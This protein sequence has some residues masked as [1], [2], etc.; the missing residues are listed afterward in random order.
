MQL[1][2]MPSQPGQLGCG[3]A[4][5]RKVA[6]QVDKIR[7]VAHQPLAFICRAAVAPQNRG[8]QHLQPVIEQDGAMHLA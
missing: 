2:L 7:M 5:H 3:E 4:G 1:R 6:G 8:T